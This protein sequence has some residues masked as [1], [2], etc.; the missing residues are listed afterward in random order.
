M[1]AVIKTMTFFDVLDFAPTA[2]EIRHFL[3]GENFTLE[4]VKKILSE[5]PCIE[6]REGF[7]ML[8][9]R[10]ELFEIRKAKQ[11]VS[12]RFL[13]KVARY[14]WLFRILPFIRGIAV[15]NNLALSNVTEK[16]DIDLF[17][18][19]KR[20]RLFLARTIAT[21]VFHL[22]GLRRHHQKISGRFCLS[23]WLSEDH[24]DFKKILFESYEDPYLAFWMR[25]LKPVTGHEI[26]K[27]LF[28]E[29]ALW[30]SSY[31][32]AH[33]A[34]KSPNPFLHEKPAREIS[35]VTKFE[36]FL[37]RYQLR[38]IEEKRKRLG[39]NNGIKADSKMLKFHDVDR[40][41][42]YYDAFK[43]SLAKFSS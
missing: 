26:F 28:E 14:N 38:R 35:F 13:K 25:S 21:L 29:N 41:K 23:F 15:C 20:N 19:A 18:I 27:K 16:S 33:Y 37:E 30:L 3:Y 1:N 12:K 10:E 32:P 22:F 39:P 8:K 40:R 9:G 42:E 4:E 31:F 43:R 7:F 17:I 11:D 34:R 5:S 36:K 6:K 2:D 24:L